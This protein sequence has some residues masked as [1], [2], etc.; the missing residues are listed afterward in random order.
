M[1]C[2]SVFLPA[3]AIWKSRNLTLIVQFETHFTLSLSLSIS[4]FNPSL[5]ISLLVV[6]SILKMSRLSDTKPVCNLGSCLLKL[7]LLCVCDREL[8]P[9]VRLRDQVIFPTFVFDYARQRLLLANV[10]LQ[11][12]MFRHQVIL[13]SE[14]LTWAEVYHVFFGYG[15]RMSLPLVYDLAHWESTLHKKTQNKR[16]Y[17]FKF[18]NQ[19]GD[20][21]CLLVGYITY[22]ISIR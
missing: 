11:S 18:S 8:V 5:F 12:E 20:K 10:Q 17:T 16:P 19:F 13:P 14:K 3:Q 9:G 2:L 6:S 15:L 4:C 1:V 22:S 21:K 7:G